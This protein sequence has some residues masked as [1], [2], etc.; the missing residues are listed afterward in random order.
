MKRLDQLETA[1]VKQ[2]HSC[3]AQ[4]PGYDKFCRTCGAAQRP[5]GFA[6][7]PSPA[8]C[9]TRPVINRRESGKSSETISSQ[10][11][12]SLT[13]SLATKTLPLRSSKFGLRLVAG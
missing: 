12:N 5:F 1:P 10:L 13:V 2:C 6:S 9:D 7:S 8:E 4:L 3:S 11:V